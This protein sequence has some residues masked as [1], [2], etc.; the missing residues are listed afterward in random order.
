M[1]QPWAEQVGILGYWDT[2]IMSGQDEARL[3]GIGPATLESVQWTY[4][5]GTTSF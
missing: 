1:P 2:R 3:G 4:G 5:G